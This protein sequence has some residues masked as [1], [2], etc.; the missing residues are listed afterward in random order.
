MAPLEHLPEVKVRKATDFFL[1]TQGSICACTHIANATSKQSQEDSRLLLPF[2]C[3][4][5]CGQQGFL[6]PFFMQNETSDRVSLG[7]QSIITY[8]TSPV[9]SL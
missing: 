8:N 2:L 3:L 5:L 7:G 6:K 9:V 4:K 1:Y